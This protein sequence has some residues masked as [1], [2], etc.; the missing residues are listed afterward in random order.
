[1]LVRT[2]VLLIVALGI[3]GCDLSFG[4]LDPADEAPPAFS[5]EALNFLVLGDWGRGG[6]FQQHAVAEAMGETADE[7]GADFVLTT[8]DNFYERGVTSVTDR[9]WSRAYESVYTASSLQIPWYVSLGNHDYLGNVSA[10]IQYSD[11]SDRWRLPARYYAVEMNVDDTTTALF[12]IIDTVPLVD[13][14]SASAPPAEVANADVAE[15]W[16][17][18]RQLAWLDSTLQHT[19]ARWRFVV[20]H[21]PLYAADGKHRDYPVLRE[22]VG[23]ILD[24][25]AVDAYIAGHVHALQHLEP[26]GTD[27]HH[28]ISGG[29]SLASRIDREVPVTFAAGV[30]GFASLSVTPEELHVVFVGHRGTVG[31][32]TTISPR[33]RDDRES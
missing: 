33:I 28:I 21:H 24:D 30:A 3:A 9:K 20:G 17:A 14:R 15:A 12:A 8:G 32:S 29:G 25:H 13:A 18:E 11:V 7:I 22:T 26:E 6:W 31:Y 27:V 1:M 2:A 5:E 19:D 23:P 16:N 10:Q 4:D